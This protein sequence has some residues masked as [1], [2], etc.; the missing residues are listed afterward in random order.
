[1]SATLR[2]A[3][4]AG[5]SRSFARFYSRARAQRPDD[6]LP[7]QLLQLLVEIHLEY[8][9]TRAQDAQKVVRDGRILLDG[10]VTKICMS[11]DNV[12]K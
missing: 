3:R 4:L 9:Q 5:T 1:M 7:L 8:A 12:N 11:F 6:Q 10:G 2:F